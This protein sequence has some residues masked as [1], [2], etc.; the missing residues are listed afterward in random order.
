[1]ADDLSNILLD[2]PYR[3]FTSRAEYRLFLRSDNAEMRLKERAHEIGMISDCDYDDWKRRRCLMESAR[4]RMAEESAMPERANEIL[5]AGGQALATERTR[6]INVFRRPGIDP[7]AFFKVA[8][9]DMQLTRRD[10][11]F[12][13]AQE[14]YAG[15]FDRQE[16]E[17]VEQKKMESV[18]LPADMDFMQV[19]AISIESR[20]RLNAHKPLT[21]G[22]ASR[23]PGVRPADI[24]V[25]AHW[26][27]NRG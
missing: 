18:R 26:L 15:F 23:V 7:E 13:Y 8:L 25:L 4:T 3:M 27:E 11:W 1:M 9:P 20:Q 16:R 14:L 17:I 2:E 24:T 21:L 6:W 19:T 5:A 22:Q 12:L 10:Q